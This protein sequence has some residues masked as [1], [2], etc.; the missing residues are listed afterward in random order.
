MVEGGFRAT[1]LQSEESLK[2]PHSLKYEPK[3][4]LEETIFSYQIF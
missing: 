1:Q 3:F 2:S 4:C